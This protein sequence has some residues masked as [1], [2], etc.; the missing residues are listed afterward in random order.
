[1]ADQSCTFLATDMDTEINTRCCAIAA[2]TIDE[3]INVD[4]MYLSYRGRFAS[5][6]GLGNRVILSPNQL[7]F[8]ERTKNIVDEEIK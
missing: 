5:G 7:G 3:S 8:L 1:M 4:T 6:D 2:P